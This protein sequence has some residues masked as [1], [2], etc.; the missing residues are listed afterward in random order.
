MMK[1]NGIIKWIYKCS[2]KYLWMVGLLTI[3][4][5]AISGSFILMAVVS[6]KIL[7]IATKSTT[8][9]IINTCIF[10]F[11]IIAFQA[12]ANII[13]NNCRVRSQAKI[14]NSMKEYL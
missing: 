13:S 4:S 2:K 10:L 1:K 12:I 3:I 8:G 7:D 5:M 11:G 9:S 6:K 14:E